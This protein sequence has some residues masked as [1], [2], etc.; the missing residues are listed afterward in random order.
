[1]KLQ[2]NNKI[3]K[4]ARS[5]LAKDKELIVKIV[6]TSVARFIAAFGTLAF[7][8]V[9]A[10]FLGV[11]EYGSFMLAYSILIG[12]ATFANFGAG[13]A[14]LRFAAIMYQ[15][16]DYQE[17]VKFQKKVLIFLLGTTGL[18]GLLLFLLRNNI[19]N[20][21]FDDQNFVNVLVVFAVSLPFYSYILIQGS[22]F[23]A[24]RKPHIAPFFT[25]GLSVFSTAILVFIYSL[26]GKEVTPFSVSLF[27]LLSNMITLL[28]GRAFLVK[29]LKGVV[30]KQKKDYTFNDNFFRTLPDYALSSITTYLL[31]FSP[32]VILGIFASSKDVGL[33]SLA[34]SAAF[35]INFILWIFHSVYAPYIAN[36]YK[37]NKLKELSSLIRKS[38]LYMTM[39]SFPIF[40]IIIIFPNTILSFFGKDFSQAVPA[41]RLLACAQ[42]FNVLTGPVYYVLQMTGHQKSLRNI[43]LGTA[44]VSVGS[45]IILSPLY[46]FMGATIATAIGLIIQNALAFSKSNRILNNQLVSKGDFKRINTFFKKTK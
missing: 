21:Y 28:L 33:Y 3:I 16:N 41:L 5:F 29:L 12:L 18:L 26:F 25:I 23:K 40:L 32:T 19:V 36:L 2:S 45:S 17:L 30:H 35:V 6:Q 7:N 34:N 9:L 42:L 20:L 14:T 10:R 4:K 22:Y 31:K 15:N 43:I 44:I 39:V 24:F 1:M 37:E 38:I 46:G 13:A 11:S 27:F 8:F